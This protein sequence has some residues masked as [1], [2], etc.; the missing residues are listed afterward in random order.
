MD[1]VSAL[2]ELHDELTTLEMTEERRQQI[3]DNNFA[4]YYC[5]CFD[6][7]SFGGEMTG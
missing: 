3:Q 6:P 2:V 7:F 5:T 1:L 4:L